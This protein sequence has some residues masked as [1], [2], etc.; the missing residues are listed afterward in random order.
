MFQGVTLCLDVHGHTQR[1]NAFIYG[2][3]GSKEF[4]AAQ[5]LL[6]RVFANCTPDFDLTSSEIHVLWP[7]F[8]LFS[9]ELNMTASKDGTCRRELNE[10]LG[11]ATVCQTFEVSLFGYRKAGHHTPY[12]ENECECTKI[13]AFYMIYRSCRRT[14]GRKVCTCHS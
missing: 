2:N 6:P 4:N 7:I 1:E 9:G 14:A 10:V 11:Q 3:E 5:M 13:I 12:L 8:V